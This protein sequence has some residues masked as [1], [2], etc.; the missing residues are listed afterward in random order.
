MFTKPLYTVREALD[1]IPLSTTGLYTLIRNGDIESHKLGRRRV[2]TA[3]AL[4][5]YVS[6]VTGTA[7][8]RGAR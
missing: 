4:N 6:K 7:A 5:N 3:Q 8:K 1:L 2:F